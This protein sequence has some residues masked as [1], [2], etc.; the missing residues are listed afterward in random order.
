M[1]YILKSVTKLYVYLGVYLRLLFKI[2]FY[3]EMHQ[4]DDF[5]FFKKL[6]LGSAYQNIKKINF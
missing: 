2:F 5:L 3:S 4:N 1:G 6:F